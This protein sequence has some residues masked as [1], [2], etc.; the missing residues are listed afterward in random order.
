MRDTGVGRVYLVGAGPGDPGLLTVRGLQ[1]LR[2]ADALVYDRLANDRLLAEARPDA[3]RIYVGKEP[4]AHTLTQDEICQLLVRLGLEGKTVCRLKGGD[5]FVFGRGGEEALALLEVGVPFEIVPGVTSAIAAAA[6]AGI[7]VT[8]RGVATSFA[9][10]T[11]HEDPTK[12]ESSI[13]WDRLATGVDTLVFLMGVGN[14]PHIVENL[15]ANGRP[16]GTPVA[17]VRWGTTP[18]QRVVT[19]TLADI[20]ERVAAARLKSPALIVVGEVVALREQLKWFDQRPLFGKRVV[21]TRSREQASALTEKLEAL[22]ASVTEAPTIRIE[23]L[24]DY[25]EVDSALRQLATYDWVVFTSVNAVQHVRRRLDVLGLDARAF[26]GVQLCAIGPATG[27]ALRQ[28]GLR[29]ELVPERFVAES[30]VEAFAEH[31]LAGKRVLLPRALEAREL[32]PEKLAERGAHVDVVP[33][34]RTVADERSADMLKQ[35]VAS[36][37]VDVLTFTAS[38]TVHNF[39]KLVGEEAAHALP[40]EVVCASIGPVTSRTAEEYGLTVAVEAS[41]HT[42]DGLADALA[43]WQQA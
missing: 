11:G 2:E 7:P 5:P 21:V 6:Y 32:I 20:V 36:G 15:V 27:A 35:L 40:A 9:A 29:P 23:D 34:Y 10:I 39:V 18:K 12:G 14:L 33:V 25:A 16:A 41:E 13:R 28:F 8:H 24:A 31:D 22:G 17:L 4:D 42:I 38:S 19:G 3:E 26:G 30:V 37:E 1:C 43:A